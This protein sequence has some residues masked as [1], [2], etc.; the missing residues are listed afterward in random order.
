MK[1]INSILVLNVHNVL[2]NY[3]VSLFMTKHF[4]VCSMRKQNQAISSLCFTLFQKGIASLLGKK[5]A[6]SSL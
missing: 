4:F 5:F 6:M 2:H 1:K 3:I